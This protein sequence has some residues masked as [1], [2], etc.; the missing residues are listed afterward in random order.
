MT[1]YNTTPHFNAEI[2]AALIAAAEL[3]QGQMSEPQLRRPSWRASYHTPLS[4]PRGYISGW[5]AWDAEADAMMFY[6]EPAEAIES[7]KNVKIRLPL[8]GSRLALIGGSP[9]CLVPL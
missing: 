3:V 2:N 9:S 8:P 5:V 1:R 7:F 6:P 4:T